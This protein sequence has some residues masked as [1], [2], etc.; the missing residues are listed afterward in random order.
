MQ[1]VRWPIAITT[2]KRVLTFGFGIFCV[3]SVVSC[4]ANDVRQLDTVALEVRTAINLSDAKSL[5]GL[6]ALP[7][8]IR[9][10]QWESASDGIGFKLSEYDDM[11]VSRNEEL[12]PIL[13]KF[14]RDVQ[15]EGDTPI[16]DD[17]NV[18]QFSDELSG[19]ESEWAN[20]SM[21]LFLRGMGDVEHVVVLGF[22][23][24]T[25]KLSAIYIN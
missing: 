7:L 5:A 25:S 15:I 20:L 17:V 4:A 8:N 14:V 18:S 23:P 16:M 22:D 2:M 1:S 19:I 24:K 13:Q 6:V 21:I 3:L 10:Q 11:I 12:L 9:Q